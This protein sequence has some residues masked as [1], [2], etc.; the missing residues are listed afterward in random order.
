MS[1]FMIG[2]D[3]GT[4][5]AS[6]VIFTPQGEVVSEYECAYS[7]YHPKPSWSEQNPLE[8]EKAAREAITNSMRQNNLIASDIIGL[9]ISSPMHSLLCIN[10]F[11]VS[12]TINKLDGI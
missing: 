8:V 3:I 12:F 2:L 9:S 5:T 1:R 4:T 6:A 7:T 10:D 11:I